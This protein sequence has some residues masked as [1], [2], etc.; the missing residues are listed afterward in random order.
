MFAPSPTKKLRRQRPQLRSPIRRTDCQ[1]YPVQ[2]DQAM[3]MRTPPSP[4]AQSGKQVQRS[5]QPV[6]E[7]VYP[8]DD[9]VQHRLNPANQTVCGLE[10]EIPNRSWAT[11]S[12][13]PSP[14]RRPP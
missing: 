12:R 8:G 10:S 1:S 11:G 5:V 7:I 3:P 14:H 13:S 2:P 4:T 6:D 9:A